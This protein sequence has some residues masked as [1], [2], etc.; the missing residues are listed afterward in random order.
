MNGDKAANVVSPATET[1]EA[2]GDCGG[3]VVLLRRVLQLWL[4]A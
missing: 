2:R 1:L 3:I 4:A